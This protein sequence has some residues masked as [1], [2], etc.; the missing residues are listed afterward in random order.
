MKLFTVLL[1]N[2]Q[3]ES[4]KCRGQQMVGGIVSELTGGELYVVAILKELHLG[5]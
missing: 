5:E 2:G 1:N 3:V 4:I